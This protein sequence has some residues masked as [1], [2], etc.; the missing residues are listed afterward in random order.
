MKNERAGQLM[1]K[2][3]FWKKVFVTSL[4]VGLLTAVTEVCWIYLL[5][6][7][8]PERRYILPISTFH[9]FVLVAAILDTLLVVFGGALAGIVLLQIKKM[10]SWMSK[11]GNMNNVMR[12]VIM[13]APAV[14]LYR[15]H[16]YIYFVF[17]NKQTRF[18]VAIAGVGIIAVFT[19]LLVLAIEKVQRGSKKNVSAIIF[20]SAIVVLSVVTVFNFV[21]HRKNSV[22][23]TGILASPENKG[24]NVVLVTIDTLRAD[25]VGCYGNSVVATPVLD[26][27]AG[28]GALFVN[29]FSQ[30]PYTTPSHCSI[31]TSTYPRQH[32]ALNGSAMM[33]VVPTMAEILKANG[34][35]TGAFISAAILISKVTGLHYGFEHYDDSLSKYT[36][37][38]RHDEYQFL[39][40]GNTFR[41][42]HGEQIRG[43]VITDKASRWLKNKKDGPFFTWLHY[44]DPHMPY[45]APEP[46]KNMY[47][48]SL[49]GGEITYADY[50]LGRFIELLK[51]KGL[52][53]NS[54]II[55][56]ADH[57]EAFG[58]KH[59]DVIERGHG[60]YLYDTT[61]H[62]PLIIKLP[63]GVKNMHVEH[64]VESI[65]IAPTIMDYLGIDIP[66]SFQGESM[67]DLLDGESRTK[68]G[69]A[70]AERMP[71]A[72]GLSLMS[73]DQA[74]EEL[75]VSFR[76]RDT[77]YIRNL[78]GTSKEL[79]HCKED[80]EESKNV[81][82]EHP[83]LAEECS[84]KIDAALGERIEIPSTE[85]DNRVLE[86]L[87]SLGY[88]D[89]GD[90]E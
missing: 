85:I 77:K 87:R 21:Q 61:Q 56:T 5:P 65:D 19:W 17:A 31:L 71:T 7:V 84:A 74:D 41:H 45:D 54:L 55:V 28:D 25:H 36:D 24:V 12:F 27:L 29:A 53:D 67:L 32:G 34:Y 9:R 47:K 38:F 68:A 22:R 86:Q 35:T 6:T 78:S 88:V 62:V 48:G 14:C 43:D 39:L 51:S 80:P 37:I 89:D 33:S 46:Y 23:D 10:S 8:F 57:G 3:G 75:L 82:A 44:Y 52:Y 18:W 26:A 70:F 49:Y 76:S 81:L 42:L 11:P 69:R 63:G 4:S 30:S 50:Q 59:G 72:L 90:E 16:L 83:E 66:E 73:K 13:A 15:G 79:Y 1:V 60:K 20:V 2:D 58:E 64:V 40:A